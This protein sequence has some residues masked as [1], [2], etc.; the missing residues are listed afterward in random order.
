MQGDTKFLYLNI[1]EYLLRFVI[2]NS[3]IINKIK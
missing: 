1:N 3:H 2:P